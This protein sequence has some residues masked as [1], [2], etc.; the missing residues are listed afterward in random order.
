VRVVP[1]TALARARRLVQGL[2]EEARYGVPFRGSRLEAALLE[3]QPAR[4]RRLAAALI[5]EDPQT[6]EAVLRLEGLEPEWR[7]A[8]EKA[9]A[10]D[11]RVPLDPA[12]VAAPAQA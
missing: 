3:E 10:A 7:E 5:Q 2:V 6:A 8:A 11:P 4:V 1:K 9:L 12:W